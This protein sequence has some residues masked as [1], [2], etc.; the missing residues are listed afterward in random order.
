M[1]PAPANQTLR[2]SPDHGRE[3]GL[4]AT[5]YRSEL[6]LDYISK[7]K[8]KAT[9]GGTRAGPSDTVCPGRSNTPE[10]KPK[11]TIGGTQ[12]GLPDTVCFG[13]LTTPKVP[14]PRRRSRAPYIG[15][16][17]K[18]TP[19]QD[20]WTQS[21]MADPILQRSPKHGGEMRLLALGYR[22]ELDLG[23]ILKKKTQG[24][25][26]LLTPGCRPELDLG[27]ISKKKFK[28]TIRGTRARLLDTVCS[29]RPNTPE[30]TPEQDHWTQ[31]AMADPILQRS[32]EY[33]GEM[34]LL[35]PG[36]RPELNFG[37]IPK[38]KPKT[39]IEDT[40]VGPPD[41]ICSGRPNTPEKKPKAIIGDTQAG[42]LDTVYSGKPNTPEDYWTQSAQA[43]PELDLGFISKKKTKATISGTRVGPP[44][45]TYSGKL[46][47]LEVPRIRRRNEAHCI[48]MPTR[49]GLEIYF[50]EKTQGNHRR[51]QSRI[52][53]SNLPKQTTRARS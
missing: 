27:F 18:V 50:K 36:C 21:A 32:P 23:F 42:P 17:T 38:K 51:Y 6:D 2:R 5:G 25:I 15:M 10:K 26:G 52:I 28:A 46:N 14:G 1:Q 11:A 19:E 35:A 4:L 16:L 12:E 48:G 53:E 29:G 9:I 3:V 20:H 22:P 31:S 34:R 8:R 41:T 47:T 49:V 24:E 33:E 43:D 7:K 13:R 39:T 37:F 40:R 44:D 45:T 30:V